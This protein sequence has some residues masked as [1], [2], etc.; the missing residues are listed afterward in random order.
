MNSATPNQ[1][2]ADADQKGTS[3]N[4]GR[5]ASPMEFLF[6]YHGRYVDGHLTAEEAGIEDDDVI[7]AV[8]I[9]DLTE[10]VVNILRVLAFPSP[11]D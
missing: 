4:V 11:K 3:F 5:A 7:V 9:M 6:S 8:E 1:H 10:D 2:L